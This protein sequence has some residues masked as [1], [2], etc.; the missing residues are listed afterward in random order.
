[1]EIVVVSD[2]H[3]DVENLLAYLDKIKELK[4]DVVVCPG[5]FTDVNTPKGFT[6][7]DIAKLIINELK[8]LNAPVLAVPGNVD[9]KNIIELL[10]RE[11][12][13]LHGCGKIIGDYGFYGYGGAKTPFETNIEPSE[14]EL[15][16][17]LLTAYKSIERVKFKV[18]ITHA[19]PS[20]T[21]LDM[22]RS[23]VHVGSDA[24]RKF[25]E[26]HTPVLAISA[27][28]HEARGIDKIN[29]TFLINSGRFPEGYVGLVNIENGIANGKILNI[30]EWPV[31]FF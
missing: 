21:V 18:Q 23:G 28:I 3:G 14:E 27:H 30:I 15:N 6:Q 31:Y 26:E 1:M 20:G 4:F 12:V 8:T 2:I 19:P 10:E 22:I 16:M 5:D 24:V 7:E 29:K 17:G 25:I 13:S 9:P 11:G